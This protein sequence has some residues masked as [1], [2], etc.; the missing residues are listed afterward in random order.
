MSLKG[1]PDF[2][3]KTAGDI[4]VY[5]CFEDNTNHILVPDRLEIAGLKDGRPDFML[6]SVRGR[7]P[8]LPPS[9]YG[10]LDMG[11]RAHYPDD[12]A[13]RNLREHDPRAVLTPAVFSSGFLRLQPV[14]DAVDIP[15]ELTEPVPLNCSSPGISRFSLRISPTA[16]LFLKD[17][18]QIE[19][20]LIRAFAELELQGVSPRLSL[21]VSFNPR[22]LLTA[23]LSS[24]EEEN[25]GNGSDSR[26]VSR[27]S[28]LGFFQKE[29]AGLPLELE[30]ESDIA[31]AREKEI[32]AEAM[33]HRVVSRFGTFVPCPGENVEPYAGL[34]PPEEAGDGVFKWDLSTPVRVS[35]PLVLALEPLES[36]RRVVKDRGLEAVLDEIVVPPIPTGVYPVSVSANL[37]PNLTGILALG[38]TLKVPP[39][40]PH[41]FQQLVKS[42]ELFPPPPE[43]AS[44]L[45]RFS[46]AE[47]PAY[48]FSTYAVIKDAGG[49]KQLEGEETPHTGDA[50]YLN[51]VHFPVTFIPV[52]ASPALL[53]LA[54]LH[55][56]CRWTAEGKE[57][58]Q[59]VV[60][61]DNRSMVTV[62]LPGEAKDAVLEF[63]AQ[64]P[65]AAENSRSIILGPFP[66]AALRL[67]LHSFPGYGLHKI[68]I[69]CEFHD[70]IK[71]YAV[72][73]L[74]ENQP[75]TSGEITVL[76]FTP[77][78]PEKE[79]TYLA[80]SPFYPGFRYRPHPGPEEEPAQ[81]S[82]VCSPFESLWIHGRESQGGMG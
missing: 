45:L 77:S 10:V 25:H 23:L 59:Q 17:A 76:H 38:V 24:G 29:T 69:K 70:N 81:W 52:E 18:L 55:G 39:K 35:R 53:K 14:G 16:T 54:V 46:P 1:L 20:L 8:L 32:F 19:V 79:W 36:A 40:P 41:R 78:H 42:V 30:G 4:P 47:T 3:E 12:Q 73:L 75:E 28:I 65:E 64:S 5:Y 44:V 22:E 66:A 71:L 51:P 48:Y 7:N 80:P 50:L 6:R 58:E 37:P 2:Q 60:L 56:I 34:I 13:L 21:R 61:D 33:T 57:S 9:P 27:A 43:P 82:D 26:L 62:A 11:I 67:G 68:K 63:R 31:E 72:D 74:A 15:A 49:I